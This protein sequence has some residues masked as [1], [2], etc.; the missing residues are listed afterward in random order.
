MERHQRVVLQQ[1]VGPEP[2]G[3][4]RSGDGAERVGGTRHEPEEE[5]GH[6]EGDECRPGDEGVGGLAAEPPHHGHDVAGEDEPPQQDRPRQRGPHARDRVEQRRRPAV[7]GGDEGEGEVV[8]DE[9]A[10]HGHRGEDGAPQ[11]ESGVDAPGAHQVGTMTGQAVGDHRHPD[12][13]RRQ[14]EQDAAVPEGGVHRVVPFG[15]LTRLGCCWAYWALWSTMSWSETNEAPGEVAHH[16]HRDVGL[17]ELG[18]IAV[19][20]DVH[21]V[22]GA[23]GHEGD[24]AAGCGA[25][26]RGRRHLR[27]GRSGSRASPCA[28]APGRRSRSS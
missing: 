26:C 10:L 12:D 27:A 21:A 1:H 3:R 18:G 9:R 4:H 8:G 22:L 13:R 17:E 24:A 6:D 23:G 15:A 11:H 5:G 7:V 16:H 25:P 20:D 28:R 14:A 2:V 19:V